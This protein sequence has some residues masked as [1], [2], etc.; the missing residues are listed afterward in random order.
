MKKFQ[1][2]KTYLIKHY[3]SKFTFRKRKKMFL[4]RNNEGANS[5]STTHI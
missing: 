1:E 4:N 3:L 2:L 5:N